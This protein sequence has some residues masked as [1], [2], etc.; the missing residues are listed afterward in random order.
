VEIFGIAVS[1]E[2]LRLRPKR[3]ECLKEVTIRNRNAFAVPRILK[4][5]EF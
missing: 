5:Q 1:R 3:N 4:P 2:R